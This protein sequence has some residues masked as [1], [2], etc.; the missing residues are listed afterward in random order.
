MFPG[1]CKLNLE[2]TSC[3]ILS[4]SYIAVSLTGFLGQI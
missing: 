4:K 3:H 1:K 2:Q